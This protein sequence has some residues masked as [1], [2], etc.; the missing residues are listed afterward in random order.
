[1]SDEEL[2]HVTRLHP[3]ILVIPAMACSFL[4]GTLSLVRDEPYVSIPILIALVFFVIRL[5]S[6]VIFFVTTEYG[7][8]S[9]RVLGKTGFIYRSALDLVLLKVEAVRLNQTILG[10]ILNYGTVEVTGTG[11]TGESLKFIPDP[12]MFRNRIQEQLSLGQEQFSDQ[13]KVV[14]E[15]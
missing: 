13:G 10:R 6:R 8:T 4:A 12:I 15:G 2:V 5:I 11:G 3:I 7:I 9:K 1:M 14:V